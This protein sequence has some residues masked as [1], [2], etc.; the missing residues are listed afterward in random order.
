[1]F[2][3]GR[4]WLARFFGSPPLILLGELSFSIYLVHSTI[5]TFYNAYWRTDYIKPD[6][7]GLAVCVT[8]TIALSFAIW[9]V[10]EAPVRITAKRWLRKR[11]AMLPQLTESK[12]Q[13]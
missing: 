12:E 7:L 13:A 10:I 1:M 4:G 11:S 8:A 6:Y 9:A 3:F 5:F 2:A